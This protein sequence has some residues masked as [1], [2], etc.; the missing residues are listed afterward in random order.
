[1]C[2]SAGD[3]I[4]ELDVKHVIRSDPFILISGD[5]ISNVNLRP[6]IEEHKQRKKKDSSSIMTMLF[7]QQ[8]VHSSL[9]PLESDLVVAKD[10]DT[11]QIVLYDDHLT[12]SH[13]DLPTV[14]FKEHSEIQFHYDLLDCHI[15]ICSPD[16][17]VQ[18][19][20][21]FDYLD[22][23]RDFVANEVQNYELGNKLHAKIITKEYAARV[24]DPRTYHSICMD[25]LDRWTYPMVPDN[26][27]LDTTS[28]SHR[29]HGMYKECNVSL[30]RSTRIGEKTLIGAGSVLG[31]ECAIA[32]GMIGRNCRIGRQVCISA[33]HLWDNVTVHDNVS[34]TDSIICDNV[35]IH[36]GAVIERGCI[37]S[38]GVVIGENCVVKEF[39]KITTAGKVSDGF[40]D[41]EGQYETPEQMETETSVVGTNGH[42]R[43]WTLDEEALPD[44]DD[45][46]EDDDATPEALEAFQFRQLKATLLGCTELRQER[47]AYWDEYENSSTSGGEDDDDSLTDFE[48]ESPQTRFLR[49]VSE[50][51][52]SGD[53]SA[54]DLDNIFLEIKSFKFAQ[55]RSFMDCID[56]IVPTLLS[57]VLDENKA[58]MD[59]VAAVKAKIEKWA[60]VLKRCIMGQPE[61]YGML[62]ALEHYALAPEHREKMFPIFRYVLQIFY[63]AE[64]IQEDTILQWAT[65]ETTHHELPQD[66]HVAEFVQWLRDDEDSDDDSTCTDDSDV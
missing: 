3:A 22:I 30:A 11:D 28:Y 48:I 17:L 44:C 52:V 50:M 42:G 13:V 40:S 15:D 64:L 39:S 8:N 7:K 49:V 1:M 19:S 6:V 21:N 58:A 55:D 54:H 27:F 5:V 29:R 60:S 16:I 57:I 33:S 20:D 34:I 61:E 24:H 53:K 12:H 36:R 62:R 56:A 45:L 63:D 18:F 66:P 51:V 2:A 23:R 37:L 4:R 38:F 65:A 10:S 47:A 35:V 14:F 59:T 32:R 46:D 31:D 41:D 43:V 26:N 9:R 25:I